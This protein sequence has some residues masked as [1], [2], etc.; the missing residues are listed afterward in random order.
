MAKLIHDNVMDFGL[1]WGT[2]A[3]RVSIATAAP[4]TYAEALTTYAV[5]TLAVTGASFTIANGDSSGRKITFA[6][7]TVAVG[8]TGNVTHVS[9]CSTAGGGTLMMQ[10]TCASTSVTAGGSVI[11]SAWDVTEIADVA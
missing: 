6:A 7:A 11:I 2:L 8:T 9:L 10:G 4:T 3:N 1:S 5:G